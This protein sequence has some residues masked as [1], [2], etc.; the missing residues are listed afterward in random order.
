M[1]FWWY[2]IMFATQYLFEVCWAYEAACE[3]LQDWGQWATL[4]LTYLG[5]SARGPSKRRWGLAPTRAHPLP[6]PPRATTFYLAPAL[7]L[8]LPCP[9]LGVPASVASKLSG[10]E[11]ALVYSRQFIYHASHTYIQPI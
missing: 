11:E 5:C 9:R 10:T 4:S 7:H 6:T 2:S 1:S 3:E 8:C